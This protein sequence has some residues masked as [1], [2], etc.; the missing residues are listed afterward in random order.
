[1]SNNLLLAIN[2]NSQI[3]IDT[4]DGNKTTCLRY[5]LGSFGCSTNP[6]NVRS[7][8]NNV[9]INLTIHPEDAE[10]AKSAGAPPVMR[11]R[12]PNGPAV[13][14]K[15]LQALADLLG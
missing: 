2:A 10:D 5:E 4:V 15:E 11:I 12:I 6:I 1:M 3:V 9:E 7:A 14:T 8:C 13:F